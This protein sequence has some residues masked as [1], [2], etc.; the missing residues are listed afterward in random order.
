ME[1]QRETKAQKTPDQII[2]L[3]V[4]ILGRNRHTKMIKTIKT[5]WT[6]N[7]TIFEQFRIVTTLNL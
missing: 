2:G 6:L 5:F 1:H 7:N 3:E 4:N